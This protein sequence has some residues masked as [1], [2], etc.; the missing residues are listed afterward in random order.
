M[1][2]GGDLA[3]FSGVL[4][5]VGNVLRLRSGPDQVSPSEARV[6]FGLVMRPDGPE[7]WTIVGDK[8]S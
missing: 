4:W 3:G 1:V 5:F 2:G 8:G 6:A 7:N